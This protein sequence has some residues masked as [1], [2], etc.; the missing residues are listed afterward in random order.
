MRKSNL[1]NKTMKIKI[2]IFFLLC[3]SFAGFAKIHPDLKKELS[4]EEI[5]YLNNKIKIKVIFL[6]NDFSPYWLFLNNHGFGINKDYLDIF[7]EYTGLQ[8]DTIIANCE[9]ALK[10]LET[11]QAELIPFI[12]NFYQ[13]NQLL[14]SSK[15][16]KT[17]L[18]I[19]SRNKTLNKL[20]DLSGNNVAIGKNIYVKKFL[21]QQIAGINFIEYD[22]EDAA[23]DALEKN[24]MN[25]LAGEY[26][27]LLNKLKNKN[28]KF[29]INKNFETISIYFGINQK[30]E[31]LLNI[32]NKVF[33]IIDSK[34]KSNILKKYNVNNNIDFDFVLYPEEIDYINSLP[35]LKI[36]YKTFRVPLEYSEN[37]ELQGF[38]PEINN[39]IFKKIN[40]KT[41]SVAYDNFDKLLND[42]KTGKI[43]I[44]A[45]LNYNP[46][47][48]KY[49]LFSDSYFK[50]SFVLISKEKDINSLLQA[51][52]QTV[53]IYSS[54][55]IKEELIKRYPQTNFTSYLNFDKLIDDLNS[56]TID[57]GILHKYS[58]LYFKNKLD[59]N[60]IKLCFELPF[61]ETV[62][63]A[64]NEKHY[65]LLPILN[66]AIHNTNPETIS[67]TILSWHIQN[68]QNKEKSNYNL[69]IIC[70]ILFFVI[71]HI[72]V[73]IFLRK[74]FKE[75]IKT[76]QKLYEIKNKNSEYQRIYNNLMDVYYKIDFNGTILDISPSITEFG[77]YLPEEVIGKPDAFFYNDVSE[78]ELIYKKF[79]EKRELI[80]ERIHLKHKSGKII[81]ISLNTK[82]VFDENKNPLF[83]EGFLRNVETTAKLEK[84]LENTIKKLEF[85]IEME[86]IGITLILPTNR[87][88][89]ANKIFYK[90]F[91][92]S[93]DEI[94]FQ[95][96]DNFIDFV[97]EFEQNIIKN[98]FEA[99][100]SK[101]IYEFEHELKIK[102]AKGNDK[103]I[104]SKF[105]KFSENE[106]EI[107]IIGLHN[108]ISEKAALNN[109]LK[110]NEIEC[111]LMQKNVNH[112]LLYLDKNLNIIQTKTLLKEINTD[113]TGKNLLEV[114]RFH[115][116]QNKEGENLSIDKLNEIFSDLEIKVHASIY[117]S[118]QNEVE[119][120]LNIYFTIP[121]F[122]KNLILCLIIDNTNFIKA[123]EESANLSIQ[124]KRLK[125]QND[126][127][128][129][130]IAYELREPISTIIGFSQMLDG[131][132]YDSSKKENYLEIIK[133]NSDELISVIESLNTLSDISAGKL[134]IF[135]S[136]FNIVSLIDEILKNLSQ[137]IE[138]KNIGIEKIIKIPKTG[139]IVFSDLQKISKTLN[140]LFKHLIENNNS[141]TLIIQ[142]SVIAKLLEIKIRPNSTKIAEDKYVSSDLF[143][144]EN[145]NSKYWLQLKT[146][147]AFL[148][149]LGGYL[150]LYSSKSGDA[151]IITF[152]ISNSS[153]NSVF[154]KKISDKPITKENLK[155][156]ILIVED[157]EFNYIYLSE[158]FKMYGYDYIIA[159][160]GIQAIKILKEKENEINLI[161]MDIRM[162][163]M[164]GIET[165]FEIRK[166]NQK[167][168]IIIQTAFNYDM[169]YDI[170]IQKY[171]NDFIQKPII[172]DILINK[173]ETL[174]KQ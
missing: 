125:E 101:R 155:A 66:R 50:N 8:C 27:S 68:F 82:I 21:E 117:N 84:E 87:T 56:E 77:G 61:Q 157:E 38:I 64:I 3:L 172:S 167:I 72:F 23:F 161:L 48:A 22:S 45:G 104:Y 80:N 141:G 29:K 103:T 81:P 160:S 152:E 136:S 15:I 105:V 9:N 78:R 153:N 139:E 146:F 95:T 65:Q 109:I 32:V 54:Y 86:N 168:P 140:F 69:L 11:E 151:A 154:D 59:K 60:N 41:Q 130:S 1:I 13:G 98:G 57:F 28:L 97:S 20:T 18:V 42:L 30:D 52:N 121:D 99:I 120:H 88:F 106:N 51:E 158:I 33:A 62:C 25:F 14:F 58:Y 165:S 126:N 39:L 148:E 132:I 147:S 5:Q 76:N 118:K 4:K 170:K 113:V 159:T 71:V 138:S 36:G 43:D 173:I 46:E 144:N 134:E 116:I 150:K 102:D 93:Y 137:Q 169:D 44:I 122:D 123:K 107:L 145:K 90:F 55:W 119:K 156:K 94:P 114:F 166:F 111:S 131:N 110:I 10:L 75:K 24:A 26:F 91:E 129:E 133:K 112:S 31:L 74:Q 6:Q 142:I 40:L 70:I 100:I 63:F 135:K 149:H 53:G 37:G 108:D 128:V 124:L 127:L 34:F 49:F 83:I 2:L 162:P 35:V 115:D 164:D 47:R 89:S 163:D 17:N 143:F 67:N 12:T 96:F 16:V 174:L 85:I 19:I 79:Y 92:L 7:L 73:I 171:C